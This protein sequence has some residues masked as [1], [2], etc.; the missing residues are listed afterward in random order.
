MPVSNAIR[1]AAR[2]LFFE[3]HRVAVD[4]GSL[5]SC[6]TI[7]TAPIRRPAACAR[8]WFVTFTLPAAFRDEIEATMHSKP[9]V[10]ASR[11]R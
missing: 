6:W 9:E 4:R 1:P 2:H 5:S 11:G 7:R 10:S 8:H 3:H